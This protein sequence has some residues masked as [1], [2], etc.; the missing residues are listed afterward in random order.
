MYTLKIRLL[1]QNVQVECGLQRMAAAY[2]PGKFRDSAS[3]TAIY[4]RKVGLQLFR[5]GA[6]SHAGI[7]TE[8]D[9]PYKNFKVRKTTVSEPYK[10]LRNAGRNSLCRRL[11][12]FCPKNKIA[13][14]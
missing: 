12:E 4:I 9:Q 2:P 7:K 11:D 3:A 8:D 14:K 6:L 1:F 13:Q 5:Y 10:D